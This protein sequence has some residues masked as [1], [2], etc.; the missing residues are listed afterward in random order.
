MYILVLA[1]HT[2]AAS[3]LSRGLK[4]ENIQCEPKSFYEN[5]DDSTF[6]SQFDA[7][8]CKFP[9]KIHL[10]EV[11]FEKITKVQDNYPFFI[12]ASSETLNIIAPHLKIPIYIYPDSI[13]IRTLA[14][15]I[16]K[17]L[18]QEQNH[19]KNYTI[20]IADMVLNVQTRE[21]ERFKRKLFLRNK[22]FQLLEYLMCNTDIVLSRQKILENVWDRNANLFTHTVDVH[23][24]ALRRKIDYN[25]QMKLIETVYCMGYKM[26]SSPNND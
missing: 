1:E 5:W 10:P 17:C 19:K 11:Q 23:I 14:Y 15:E 26:H 9:S 12:I 7:I 13:T 3:F 25:P 16:K 22:E 4:Y 20:T 2:M 18:L 6:L 21:V 24:N 8:I